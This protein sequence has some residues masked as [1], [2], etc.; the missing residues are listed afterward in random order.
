MLQLQILKKKQTFMQMIGSN[1]PTNI[2]DWNVKVRNQVEPSI[3]R[4]FGLN[5]AGKWIIEFCKT[6]YLF[7]AHT[8]P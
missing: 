6:N 3:S 2:S 1:A 5:E 8:S 4:E 7:M